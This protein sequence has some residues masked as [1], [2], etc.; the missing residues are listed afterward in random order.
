MANLDSTETDDCPTL[1]TFWLSGQWEHNILNHT[2]S[3]YFKDER[4]VTV[5]MA[6]T[7]LKIHEIHTVTSER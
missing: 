6:R 2:P 1:I 4:S 7:L 3:S 5:L